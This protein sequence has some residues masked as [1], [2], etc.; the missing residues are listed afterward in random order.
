MD[1]TPQPE[2]AELAPNRIW[3]HQLCD[4]LN[5]YEINLCA[6]V[7]K[8]PL[9]RIVR[10]SPERLPHLIKLLR[11][12]SDDPVTR[13][14]KQVNAIRSGAKDNS[15]F[16][17]YH[18]DRV[19]TLPWAIPTILRPTKIYELVEQPLIGPEKVGDT[20]YLKEFSNTQRR[21]RYRVLVCMTVGQSLL[22]PISFH[23][24]ERDNY[25]NQYKQIWPITE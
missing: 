13:P 6:P 11:R 9:G 24:R 7:L 1:K 8:D 21:Y 23:P 25:S 14:L 2:R 4:I 18:E 16:G 17:G 5:W 22:A 12:G 15:H 20:I 10:F 19:H 3:H